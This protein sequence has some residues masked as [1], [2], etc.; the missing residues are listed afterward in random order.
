MPTVIT[1]HNGCSIPGRLG[2]LTGGTSAPNGGTSAPNAS[3]G[4]SA[5]NNLA[6]PAA[7]SP[8]L[9]SNIEMENR[10]LSP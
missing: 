10:H 1:P 5:P 9:A 2:A 6:L 3:G 8:L 4:P 7:V